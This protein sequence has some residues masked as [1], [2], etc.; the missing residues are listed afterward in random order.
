MSDREIIETSKEFVKGL[1]GKRSTRDMC[2]IVSTALAGYLN[3]IGVT[4]EAV[5]GLFDGWHHWWVELDD[6]RVIDAT[7]NQFKTNDK[8]HRHKNFWAEH[9]DMHTAEA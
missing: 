2:F 5:E 7:A 8:R 1:L 6:G 9:S 3:A 4:C